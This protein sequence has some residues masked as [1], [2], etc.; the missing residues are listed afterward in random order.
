MNLC[1]HYNIC[2]IYAQVGGFVT[3]RTFT[4]T[5]INKLIFVKSN[6]L[7]EYILYVLIQYIRVHNY[8]YYY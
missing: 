8:Y 1:I 5:C 6:E 7:A 4:F 3:T 2:R